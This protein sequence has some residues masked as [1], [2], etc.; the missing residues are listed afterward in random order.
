MNII[1]R[2]HRKKRQM[3][4]TPYIVG[5][6]VLLMIVGVVMLLQKPKEKAGGAA[7]YQQRVQAMPQARPQ[8]RERLIMTQPAAPVASEAAAAASTMDNQKN[9]VL[10]GY[11]ITQERRRP[12]I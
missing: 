5:V 9:I 12:Q 4:I 7:F 2:Q 11:M 6:V 1:F 10:N 8:T 3:D